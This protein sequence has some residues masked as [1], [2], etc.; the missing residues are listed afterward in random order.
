MNGHQSHHQKPTQ[1]Y[2]FCRTDTA[3]SRTGNQLLIHSLSSLRLSSYLDFYTRSI[4]QVTCYQIYAQFHLIRKD[5]IDAINGS[6][7]QENVNGVHT[8]QYQLRF[9][10]DSLVAHYCRLP[11][12][13]LGNGYVFCVVPS[14]QVVE[15]KWWDRRQENQNVFE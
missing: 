2:Q 13:P 1:E 3:Y 10:N 11:T 15:Q 6:I 9:Y 7:L 8:P 4:M 5:N 14:V 12:Q